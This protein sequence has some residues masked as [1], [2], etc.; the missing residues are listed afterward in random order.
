[1]LTF[2]KKQP[3]MAS[4]SLTEQNSAYDHLEHMSA[5][6]LVRHI[7]AEDKLV[8]DAVERVLPQI[9][10]LVDQVAAIISNGGRLFYIGAGTSGRLGVLDASECPPT[11]GVPHGLVI[12]IIAGGD[13]AI[14]KAVEGAEDDTVQ[15]FLDLQHHLVNDKD[16]VI[17]LSASGRT[18][19]VVGAMKACRER[20][21]PTACITCNSGSAVTLHA[22]AAIEVLTGPE[23][24]TGST[25]MKAGTAQKL[26]LNMISTGAMIRTGRVEGNKM[27]HMSMSNTKLIERGIRMIM[28]KTGLDFA[29]SKTLLSRHDYNIVNALQAF[30]AR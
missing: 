6:E 20:G 3:R 5:L 28:E 1:M 24:V 17:G 26:V 23:F 21:I 8:A 2:E 14:R 11:F 16:I 13:G 19:Y 29:A 30:R 27:V 7:N 9:A 4:Q 10:R 25:R 12:G 18:P 22:D 15:G